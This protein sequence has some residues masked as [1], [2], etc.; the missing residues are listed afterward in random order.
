MFDNYN[1][2]GEGIQT[3]VFLMKGSML[4]HIGWVEGDSFE[5]SMA[6]L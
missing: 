1:N 4:C 6:A 5:M 2:R 3:I